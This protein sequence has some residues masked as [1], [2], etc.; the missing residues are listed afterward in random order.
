MFVWNRML[1][2]HLRSG[3]AASITQELVYVG[4]MASFIRLYHYLAHEVLHITVCCCTVALIKCSDVCAMIM[5]MM[6]SE[7]LHQEEQQPLEEPLVHM[8]ALVC[9]RCFIHIE[10]VAHTHVTVL[11]DAFLLPVPRAQDQSGS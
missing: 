6:M 11:R 3:L 4:T 1:R 8:L 7:T 10:L 9:L 5:M 2:M